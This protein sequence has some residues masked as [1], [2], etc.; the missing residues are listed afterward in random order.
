MDVPAP[1]FLTRNGAARPRGGRR[2]DEAIAAQAAQAAPKP[3]VGNAWLKLPSKPAGSMSFTFLRIGNRSS[4][5]V[6]LA[7]PELI[8]EISFRHDSDSEPG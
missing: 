6:T 7:K 3:I 2:I 5:P 8:T 1:G 4:F